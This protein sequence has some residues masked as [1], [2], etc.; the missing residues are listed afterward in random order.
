MLK[1]SILNLFTYTLFKYLCFY[2]LLMFIRNDFS[3]FENDL[4]D[5]T[6]YF[7]VFMLPLPVIMFVCFYLPIY[8]VLKKIK[9]R[10]TLVLLL[11][12]V[13]LEYILYTKI[14]SSIDYKN[15]IY[16]QVLGVLLFFVFFQKK[17]RSIV[18]SER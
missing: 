10:L 8:F 1:P 6:S 3:F 16:L 17:V 11:L 7:L 5:M 9:P 13:I 12:I 14:A 4:L 15:G 2:L 18:K